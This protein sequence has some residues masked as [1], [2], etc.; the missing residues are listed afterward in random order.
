[1][2]TVQ[3]FNTTYSKNVVKN[4][5]LQSKEAI[6]KSAAS[7]IFDISDTTE[8]TES[9]NA[10]EAMDLPGYFDEG[11]TLKESTTGKGYKVTF[12]SREFGHKI[13]ITKKS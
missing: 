7:R 6:M 4:Y 1:M 8:Y 10:T 13:T 2:L 5:D 11:E 9:F 3:E 12:D